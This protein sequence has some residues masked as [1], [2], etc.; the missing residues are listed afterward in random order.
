MFRIDVGL[1]FSLESV[2]LAMLQFLFSDFSSI[3]FFLGFFFLLESRTN[4]GAKFNI[5][6]VRPHNTQA[7]LGLRT[8]VNNMAQDL[9]SHP[10]QDASPNL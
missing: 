6:N 2:G 5:I 9:D 1:F 7:H 10:A 3:F 8:W 4:Y